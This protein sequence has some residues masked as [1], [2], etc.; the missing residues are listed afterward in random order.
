MVKQVLAVATF[1][2]ALSIAV[3]LATGAVAQSRFSP[4]VQVG[5]AVVTRYQLDQRTLFLS[6]LGAPGDPRELA[7][8]QLVN[9]AVQT[10]TARA[11][12]IELSQE[13]LGTA[14]EEFAGRANLTADEFVAALGQNGVDAETFRDFVGAGV[15]WRNYVREKFGETARDIPA[16]LTKRTLAQTGTEGGLRVLISEILLPANTPE[17]AAASRGRAARISALDSEEAFAAAAR[18]LS[19]APTS[20]RG[21]ELNWMA[22]ETLPDDVEAIIAGMSPG[23]ISRP[24]EQENAIAVFLLRDTERV[25]AGAPETLSVEYALFTVEGGQTAAEAIA[26]KVD[27]CEDLY[28]VAKGLPEDRLIRESQPVGALPADVRAEVERMD[29]N[30]IST[31]IVRGDNATVLVLCEREAGLRSTVD[32][33]IVGTRLLNTRLGTM[34]ADHLDDLRAATHVVDLSD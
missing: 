28:A 7:R 6:L 13:E 26:R 19:V 25:A 11:A 10:S 31:G 15:V 14:L 24:V 12:G 17:T 4:V 16:D 29:L 32:L 9:E 27:T 21:G 18:Q 8:E 23:Q 33:D 3:S 22:L 5:D 1:I 30:E 34:A 20:A 2:G